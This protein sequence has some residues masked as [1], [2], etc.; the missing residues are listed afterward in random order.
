M[1]RFHVHLSVEN[2]PNS[3]A[4]YSKLFG[5]AP[6][7]QKDDYAKWMLDDPRVNFAI[8][9]RGHARGL[10]HLGFQVET[11]V[12]LESLRTGDCRTRR[13]SRTVSNSGA[14]RFSMPA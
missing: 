13:P 7:V 2:L 8:S 10:N 9:Q 11:D 4:F 5:T 3:V 1:K 12:E 14:R 6:S